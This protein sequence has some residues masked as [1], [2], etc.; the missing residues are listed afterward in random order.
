LT[1]AS[2]LLEIEKGRTGDVRAELERLDG[3]ECRSE[4]RGTLVVLTDCE[5]AVGVAQLRERLSGVSGV[6]DAFLVACFEE[7]EGLSRPA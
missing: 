3:V 4:R 5:V 6:R 1:I 2:W 7:D